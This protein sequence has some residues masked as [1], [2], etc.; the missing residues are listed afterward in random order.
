MKKISYLVILSCFKIFSQNVHI[1]ITDYAKQIDDKKYSTF[2]YVHASYSYSRPIIV[3]VASKDVFNKVYLEIPSLY[4]SKQEYTDVYL[5]G[6]ENFKSDNVTETDKKI[7]ETFYDGIIKY[8]NDNGLPIIKK[9]S[10]NGL[11][12]FVFGN[13]DLCNYFS[14]RFKSKKK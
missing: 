8:R 1:E 4:Q 3:L 7:L 11:T 6:I 9:E 12:N 13:D 2:Q 14:C 5:L 10:M